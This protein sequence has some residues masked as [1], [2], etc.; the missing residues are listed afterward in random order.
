MTKPPAVTGFEEQG[1]AI[2]MWHVPA[3]GDYG[4][5]IT[6]IHYRWRQNSFHPDH[7][8]LPKKVDQLDPY[9]VTF[10]W[11]T[12]NSNERKIILDFDWET[13]W[14]EDKWVGYTVFLVKQDPRDVAKS[15]PKRK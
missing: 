6:R 11:N 1:Q 8:T 10:L 2:D 3:P 4:R 5:I 12:L 13:K 14:V 7:P 9:R 15:S